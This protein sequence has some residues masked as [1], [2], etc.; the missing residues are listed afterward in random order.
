MTTIRSQRKI[1]ASFQPGHSNANLRNRIPIARERRP[2][3]ED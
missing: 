2:N 3:K 1:A